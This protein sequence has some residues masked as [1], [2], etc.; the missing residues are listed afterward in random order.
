QQP[1]GAPPTPKM[2]GNTQGL[3]PHF[4]A[5]LDRL[6][7]KLKAQGY[8][9][10]RIGHAG[11][12]RT[13]DKQVELFATNRTYADFAAKMSGEVNR[14][15]ITQTDA[16]KWLDFYN[17]ASGNHPMPHDP[18]HPKSPT[19]TLASDHLSGRAAD[20]SAP[21]A[22]HNSVSKEKFYRALKTAAAEEGLSV[23]Y[24]W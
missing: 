6:A 11:G 8:S 22:E 14:G 13:L 2:P 23:P 21:A 20:V 15:H 12:V 3:D 4:Q 18:S 24:S 16:Q 10:V 17:P 5:A 9:D 1:A 7:G 19:E